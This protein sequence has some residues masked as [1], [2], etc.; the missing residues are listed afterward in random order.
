MS[1]NERLKSFFKPSFELTGAKQS[2]QSYFEESKVNISRGVSSGGQVFSKSIEFS[3]GVKYESTYEFKVPSPKDIAA[4]VLG[5]VE[6]RINAE[7][8]SGASNER[9]S[10]LMAQAKSGIDKGYAQAEKDIKDLGLMTNE[11]AEE[12]SEG[13]TLI[14]QGLD[15]IKQDINIPVVDKDLNNSGSSRISDASI[16]K[17]LLADSSETKARISPD[18]FARS[19]EIESSKGL[20]SKDIK[21]ASS[22]KQLTENTADFVLNTREGDQ[23]LIRISDLQR[24]DYAK[25]S[26]GEALNIAQSSAF[27]LTVK[28][29]LN[30]EELQAINDILA[31]V[32]NIS[33]LFFSDQFEE[34]FSSALNLGFDS[35]QIASFAL[36]LS[37]LQVQEVRTYEE[38][39]KNAMDSYKRNQPL[40]NMA[41][42]FERL[43]SLIEPLERFEKIQSMIEDLVS[44]AIERYSFVEPESDSN[45]EARVEGFQEFS[46]KLLDSMLLAE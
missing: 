35:S 41:Q 2:Q 34:A 24:V 25:N 26:S 33:S 17:T 23:I 7:K 8:S 22:L 18:L 37:K 46:K 45:S 44:K 43:D 12:I 29:D 32:G 40:I 9:L 16:E 5:F 14:N 21:T 11:L 27:E 20:N 1:S 36:D 3:L 15:K 31:Q 13:F 19:G 38:G 42:Q 10:N 28:G 6:N 4:T 30:E 39:P